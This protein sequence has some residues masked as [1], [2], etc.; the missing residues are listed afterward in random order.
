MI[1][2]YSTR[3]VAYMYFSACGWR[4]GECELMLWSK[5]VNANACCDI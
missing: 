5:K 3:E 1:A 4:A 2:I